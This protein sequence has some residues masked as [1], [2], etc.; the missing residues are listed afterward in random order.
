MMPNSLPYAFECTPNIFGIEGPVMSASMMPVLYPFLV[1]ARAESAVTM[2]FPTPPFPDTMPMTFFMELFSLRTALG[3]PPSLE[4]QSLPHVL[5]SCV[6]S[7]GACPP[8]C[9]P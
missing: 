6:Q 4:G 9:P 7:S 5:Q 2:D 3:M 1:A 8:S